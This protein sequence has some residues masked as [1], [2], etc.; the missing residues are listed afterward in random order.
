MTTKK[1]KLQNNPLSWVETKKV[2]IQGIRLSDVQYVSPSKLKPNPFNQDFFREESAEYFNNLRKDIQERGII[3]PLISKKDDT[4]LA[5]HNRLRLAQELG[6]ENIPVQYVL[7]ALPKNAEQEFIIKDNL[8]RR[9][10]SSAEWIALYKKL[11]PNFDEQIQQETRGGGL[12][13][14]KTERSVLLEQEEIANRLTADK[15]AHDT[16]QKV[17]AVQKQLSKYR[18]KVK[19]NTT[20]KQSSNTSKASSSKN[21]VN[22]VIVEETSEILGKLESKLKQENEKTIRMALKKID[23]LKAKLEKLL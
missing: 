4:L 17:S 14:S 22:T 13:W 23:S 16:G 7:D 8:F 10:F 11:Y 3:V 2:E 19:E 1:P 21:T 18:K 15:I 5:G 20:K 6:L 9:Q 12:K